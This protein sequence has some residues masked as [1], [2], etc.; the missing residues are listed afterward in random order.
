MTLIRR[1]SC[2]PHRAITSKKDRGVSLL[3]VVVLLSVLLSIGTGVF[4]VVYGELLFASSMEDSFLALYAADEGSE[5]IL[6]RD[7]SA[8]P[9]P[10]PSYT[11][12]DR[13]V[14][15]GACYTATVNK[16]G[17]VTSVSV[18]GKYQC[19]S[20]SRVVKRSLALTYASAFPPEAYWK[21]D[22][23]TTANPNPTT[24]QDSSGN[25]NVG[26]QTNGTWITLEA[27][28]SNETLKFKPSAPDNTRVTKT[29]SS[30][31]SGATPVTVLAWI[32][33]ITTGGSGKGRIM[34][35]GTDNLAGNLTSGFTLKLDSSNTFLFSAAFTGLTNVRKS[36][37]GGTS[38]INNWHFVAAT[39]DG[40]NSA[41][42]IN[43]YKYTPSSGGGQDTG[44]STSNGSLSYRPP[45]N[46]D[47]FIGN[48]ENL[49]KYG[50]N[51]CIEEAQVW[52]RVLTAQEIGDMALSYAPPA[53][54]PL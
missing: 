37:S 13:A 38:I 16:G 54:C 28:T 50:F 47:F 49:T 45:T 31:L 25:N 29:Y 14:S 34:Q 20:L 46:T 8:S 12:T 2:E 51:G 15:S 1:K 33:P 18:V 52:N 3:L 9:L 6:R 27:G 22:D 44:G 11:E 4:T 10:G 19:G 40:A 39:W 24:A 36:S 5:R 21:F 35:A 48:Q 30:T 17:G 43:I 41:S 7:L 23:P 42:G 26:T 53:S 32:Y